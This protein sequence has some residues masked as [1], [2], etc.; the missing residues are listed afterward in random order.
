VAQHTVCGKCKKA[1]HDWR[2]HRKWYWDNFF[3]ELGCNIDW[4]YNTLKKMRDNYAKKR[5]MEIKVEKELRRGERELVMK[6]KEEQLVS[7]TTETRKSRRNR[8]KKKGAVKTTNPFAALMEQ[9]C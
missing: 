2:F 9:E 6:Q 4:Y 1:G 3:K 5:T 7:R 8:N